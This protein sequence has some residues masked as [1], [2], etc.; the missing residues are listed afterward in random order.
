MKTHDQLVE[1]MMERPGVRAEVGQMTREE[2][3][4]FAALVVAAEREACAELCDEIAANY[5]NP[6]ASE[7][8]TTIRARGNK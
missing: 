3:L 2:I 5:N 4:R 7:C 1:E 6:T 8:A